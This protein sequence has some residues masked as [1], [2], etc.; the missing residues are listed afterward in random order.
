M[1]WLRCVTIRPLFRLHLLPLL[2]LIISPGNFIFSLF[3][4]TLHPTFYGT[5]SY[6]KSSVAFVQF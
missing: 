6:I 2:A 5:F 3:I 4:V 1:F